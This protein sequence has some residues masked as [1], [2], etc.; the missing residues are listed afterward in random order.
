MSI[1]P[2][3][4]EKDE[5]SEQLLFLVL[6]GSEMGSLPEKSSGDDM[7][8]LERGDSRPGVIFTWT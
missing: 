2:H 1:H 8:S 6:D 5:L 4:A 3:A 7:G